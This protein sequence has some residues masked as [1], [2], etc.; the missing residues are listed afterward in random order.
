MQQI[1]TLKKY[2]TA[3]DPAV[4][5]AVSDELRCYGRLATSGL[6]DQSQG[7]AATDCE[8]HAVQHAQ[9][10]FA[11]PVGDIE[12]GDLDKGGCH[13]HLSASRTVRPR[14]R[15]SPSVNRFRPT[16]RVASIK[17]GP[18]TVIGEKMISERFSLIMSPHS[19]VGGRMP[20]PRNPNDPINTGA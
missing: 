2:L 10:T 1:G 11:V 15:A 14:I 13:G 5:A 7:F 9:P 6:A 16:T 20:N 3:F 8:T 19:G 18:T 12:V 4:P 17:P